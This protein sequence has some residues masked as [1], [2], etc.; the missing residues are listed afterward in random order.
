MAP[1]MVILMV[2]FKRLATQMDLDGR[3]KNDSADQ[4]FFS[5]RCNERTY[6]HSCHLHLGC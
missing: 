1:K 5:N 3:Q 6:G 2:K 4:F